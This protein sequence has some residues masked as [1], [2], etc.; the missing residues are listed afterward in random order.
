VSQQVCWAALLALL[1]LGGEWRRLVGG[2]W[3]GRALWWVPL[4][5]A[6]C[7]P[8]VVE[9]GGRADVGVVLAGR[10]LR[11][12]GGLGWCRRRRVGGAVVDPDPDA[13]VRGAAGGGAVAGDGGHGSGCLAQLSGSVVWLSCL[14]QL[15]GSVVWLSCQ[16]SCLAGGGAVVGDGCRDSGAVGRGCW[17]RPW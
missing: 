5:G 2:G 11:R 14:P 10:R 9:P 15:S 8:L 17:S 4:P 1:A 13:G 6:V 7:V 3:P 12:G 16:L